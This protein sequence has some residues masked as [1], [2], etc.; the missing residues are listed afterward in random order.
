[1]GFFLQHALEGNF[2]LVVTE[3]YSTEL[4]IPSIVLHHPFRRAFTSLQV[5]M[6]F[7]SP[8]TASSPNN[9]AEES[10]S[11]AVFERW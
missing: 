3:P 1:M 11:V 10:A 2:D 4:Q 9:Q 6:S 7:L 8:S 5:E